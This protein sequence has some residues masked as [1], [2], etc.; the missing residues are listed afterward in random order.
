[1]ASR[2]EKEIEKGKMGENKD[3]GNEGDTCSLSIT[4]IRGFIFEHMFRMKH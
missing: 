3:T 1:M 4:M 2:V